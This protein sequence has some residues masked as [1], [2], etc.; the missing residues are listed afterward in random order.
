MNTDIKMLLKLSQIPGF[1]LLP[2]EEKRLNEWKM[3]QIEV[4]P[5]KPATR[6]KAKAKKS[7]KEE[8]ATETMEIVSTPEV[9]IANTS[10][11]E[12][13][14]I[15]AEPIKDFTNEVKLEDKEIGRFEE[16]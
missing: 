7:A 15:T 2:S 3:A 1:Q 6:K 12:G 16:S 5:K 9:T 13:Q 8:V 4:K 10:V 14:T 11:E